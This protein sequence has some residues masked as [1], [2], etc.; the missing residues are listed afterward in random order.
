VIHHLVGGPECCGSERGAVWL[1][2]LHA[3]I[4]WLPAG[5]CP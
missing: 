1:P 2:W 4:L 3:A 5:A